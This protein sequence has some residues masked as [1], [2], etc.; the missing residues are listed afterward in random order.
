MIINWVLFNVLLITVNKIQKTYD[1]MTFLKQRA[2]ILIVRY[3][4]LSCC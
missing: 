4:I 2:A 3:A 1:D